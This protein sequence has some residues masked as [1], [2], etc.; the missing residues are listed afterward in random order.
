[1]SKK[2]R[3]D[4]VAF[5]RNVEK[6]SEQ[7]DHVAKTAPEL[8]IGAQLIYRWEK[9]SQTWQPK[10]GKKEILL[11]S[12]ALPILLYILKGGMGIQKSLQWLF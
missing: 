2:K 9:L 1:M 11:G 3:S 5:K 12:C 8:G 4:T 6:L 7:K 10:H